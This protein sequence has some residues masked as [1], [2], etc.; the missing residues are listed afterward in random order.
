MCAQNAVRILE[1]WGLSLEVAVIEELCFFATHWNEEYK[2]QTCRLNWVWWNSDNGIY[3]KVG[4][5]VHEE[6]R[7][8]KRITSFKAYS[9]QE[10]VTKKIWPPNNS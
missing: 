1:G 5:Q 3:K 10:N 9:G 4:E 6:K 2:E 8:L 7:R